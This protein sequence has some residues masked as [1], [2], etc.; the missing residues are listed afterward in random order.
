MKPEVKKSVEALSPMLRK[1]ITHVECGFKMEKR[2]TQKQIE[3]LKSDRLDF[4]KNL[5]DKL[6]KPEG[7]YHD[8]KI[9][10]FDWENDGYFT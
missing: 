1:S 10:I 9:E 2:K 7:N 3:K 5:Q 4:V 6:P 8:P